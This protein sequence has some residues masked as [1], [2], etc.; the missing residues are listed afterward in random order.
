MKSPSSQRIK[1]YASINYRL[2]SNP[3]YP[4]SADDPSK[5]AKHPDHINDVSE[6]IIFLEE[7]YN[8]SNAG[9]LLVGHSCGATLT[10]QLPTS[11]E[12]T[13]IP[14]PL[15]ALGSEGIYDLATLFRTHESEAFY[16]DFVTRAFG[17]SES[18]WTEASPALSNTKTAAWQQATVVVIS[19]SP[20]D[21]LV[22]QI[23]ADLM[24]QRVKSYWD[25]EKKG[26]PFYM[27]VPAT[28]KHDDVWKTGDG[29]A[30]VI[31]K[32]LEILHTRG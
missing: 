14:P 12:G 2:S 30:L 22:D 24:L 9:Y 26:L 10:F 21:E 20:E 16:R 18:L 15:C 3:K 28:G 29:L 23:Q 32:A 8:I 1:G 25:E 7:N 19:H 5:N 17:F 6:A 13:A 31:S 11:Y 4:A 27:P